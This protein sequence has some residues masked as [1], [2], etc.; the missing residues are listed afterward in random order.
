[1][2]DKGKG[3]AQGYALIA[4]QKG[5]EMD[6]LKAFYF[7]Q[8]EEATTESQIDYLVEEAAFKLESNADYEE[9]YRRAMDKYRSL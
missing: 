3:H 2:K 5:K 1:M 9:V 7:R 6:S 8:I 4:M